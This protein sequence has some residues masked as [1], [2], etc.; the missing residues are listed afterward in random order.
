MDATVWKD[1]RWASLSRLADSKELR[2]S[3]HHAERLADFVSRF[4]PSSSSPEAR[5]WLIGREDEIFFFA[6]EVTGELERGASSA[7][8][9]A[10]SLDAYL[11]SLHQGLARSFGE[12]FPP[13]CVLTA[14]STLCRV[15]SP[16]TPFKGARAERP[17]P[18]PRRVRAFSGATNEIS[19]E[20]LLSGL[21]TVVFLRT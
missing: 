18:Y 7:H 9:V 17:N 20:V 6:R 11:R 4:E 5:A 13:C 12:R 8:R 1:S 10:E 15:R 21:V 19:P 16:P 14:S 2:L 3:L